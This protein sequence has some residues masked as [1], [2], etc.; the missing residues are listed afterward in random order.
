MLQLKDILDAVEL[1]VPGCPRLGLPDQLAHVDA[2]EVERA[3][4][5]FYSVADVL[6]FRRLK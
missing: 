5:R 3:E 1:D 2:V 4:R 6:G